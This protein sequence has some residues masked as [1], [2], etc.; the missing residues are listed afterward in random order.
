MTNSTQTTIFDMMLPVEVKRTDE[1]KTILFDIEE[2]PLF[3]KY[4]ATE[5]DI[6]PTVFEGYKG[7]IN[8]DNNTQISIVSDKYH[9]V[10]NLDV[11]EHFEK[12]LNEQ[13]IKFE[14]G[15]ATTARNGRKTVMEIILPEMV[16]DL[17]GGD[18]QEMRLYIQN[19]FDGGN[20]VKLEMGFFRHL[21]S[22]MA[23]MQ[24]SADVQYKTSHI[25]NAT[26][27]IKTEFD[28]YIT[29]R[30]DDA[31]DFITSLQNNS[32]ENV[33]EF[34]NDEDNKIM[35]DRDRKKVLEIY[36]TYYQN[37][38]NTLYGVYQ[39]YTQF[40]THEMN[41]TMNGKMDRLV[42]LSK[43]FNAVIDDKKKNLV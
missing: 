7:L 35:S 5:S 29:S 42:K 36:N 2:I 18:T 37:F 8:K 26:D 28:F 30:F 39:A 43:H 13:E 20:S 33:E 38:N 32:I 40:I 4:T 10:K 16:I 25:G 3:E 21:C 34:I 22:N 19:S 1:F 9:V 24:G 6:D 41:I 11:L 31:K 23:L 15:F 17:G 14:Y 27:R 12:L